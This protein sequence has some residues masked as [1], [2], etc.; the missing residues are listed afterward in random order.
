MNGFFE[1]ASFFDMP[2]FLNMIS[3]L[4]M[5][6]FSQ[7]S[8]NS[9]YSACF[10]SNQFSTNHSYPHHFPFNSSNYTLDIHNCYHFH[11]TDLPQYYTSHPSL[12]SLTLNAYFIDN[13]SGFLSA[14]YLFKLGSHNL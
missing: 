11:Y 13:V 3:F 7:F 12:I 1:K 10:Y 2:S 14:F 5:A 4:N 9:S 8:T 6:S